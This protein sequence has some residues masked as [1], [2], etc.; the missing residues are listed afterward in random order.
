MDL[1]TFCAVI[2]GYQEHLFDLKCLS[3]Y[4]GYWAGYYSNSRHPKPLSSVLSSLARE[5]K[6]AK[7][8]NTNSKAKKPRPDVDVAKFLEREQKFKARLVKRKE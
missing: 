5:H 1:P 4:Q 2:E 3:V 7:K 8:Q 6:K